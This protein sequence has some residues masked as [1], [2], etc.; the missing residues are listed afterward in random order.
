MTSKLHELAMDANF[1]MTQRPHDW[2]IYTTTFQTEK[3][4][5]VRRSMNG[6]PP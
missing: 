5:L 6:S 1:D 2:Y 3:P 4:D